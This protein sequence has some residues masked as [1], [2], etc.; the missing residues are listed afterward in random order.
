MRG[1]FHLL[2]GAHPSPTLRRRAAADWRDASRE[3]ARWVRPLE[4]VVEEEEEEEDEE[5]DAAVLPASE[6]AAAGRAGG[7][8]PPAIPSPV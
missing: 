1:P 3:A 6:P 7:T 5:D 8:A 2:S 4:A